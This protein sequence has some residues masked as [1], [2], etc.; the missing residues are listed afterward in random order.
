[1]PFVDD[2][3]YAAKDADHIVDAIFGGLKQCWQ[4]VFV[5]LTE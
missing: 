2:F 4:L 3:V 1:M 5:H